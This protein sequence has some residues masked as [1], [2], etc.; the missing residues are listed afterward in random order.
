MV[1][2]DVGVKIDRKFGDRNARYI[3][4]WGSYKNVERT[5]KKSKRGRPAPCC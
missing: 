1:G 5:K 3:M 4:H 2:H